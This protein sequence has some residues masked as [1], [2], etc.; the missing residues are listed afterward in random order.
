MTI[1][2]LADGGQA[3]DESAWQMNTLIHF[4]F[5]FQFPGFQTAGILATTNR[6]VH[7][8]GHVFHLLIMSPFLRL[9]T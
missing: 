7:L 3:I 2:V 6:F 9:Q 8:S 4:L 5:I 1:F